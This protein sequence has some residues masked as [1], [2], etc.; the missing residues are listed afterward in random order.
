MQVSRQI[1][2]KMLPGLVSRIVALSGTDGVL[3]TFDLERIS[4]DFSEH[5]I[6]E[7]K[8]KCGVFQVSEKH[9]L[10]ANVGEQRRPVN[11]GHPEMVFV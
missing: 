3:K 8:N 1:C 6:H 5:A 9:G 10:I 7:Q 2:C 11:S 4:D